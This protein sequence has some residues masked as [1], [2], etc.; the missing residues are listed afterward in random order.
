MG[1]C[2]H[3][4]GWLKASQHWHLQ[5]VGWYQVLELMSQDGGRQHQCPR[6]RKLPSMSATSIYVPRVSCSCPLACPR[7]SPSPAGMSGPG[8]YQV[9][10]LPL[11]PVHVGFCVLPVTVESLF[12][13]SPAFKATRPGGPFS[14]YR[15][16][17]LQSP[18]C[19]SELSPVGEP[20]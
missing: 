7:D 14:W 4:A 11:V 16:R 6:G 10:A 20:P 9:T 19:G 15:T 8:S 12:P 5:A 13:P 17:R 2:S 1:L 3:P 18:T